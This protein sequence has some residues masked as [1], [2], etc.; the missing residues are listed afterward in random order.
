MIR[1]V[2]IWSL[3]VLLLTVLC[4]FTGNV[5]AFILLTATAVLIIVSACINLFRKSKIDIN[6]SFNSNGEKNEI[7]F[8]TLSITNNSFLPISCLYIKLLCKNSL[9]G[10]SSYIKEAVTLMPRKSK[11][12]PVSVQSSRCGNITFFTEN[13]KLYDFLLLFR[14]RI[15]INVTGNVLVYPVFLPVN[16]SLVNNMGTDD[17]FGDSFTSK[18]GFYSGDNFE[19]DEYKYGDSLKKI[20]WKLTS[21]FDRLMVT[22]QLKE[23]NNNIL[24]M[25]ETSLSKGHTFDV[26][27]RLT[28]SFVSISNSLTEANVRHSICWYNHVSEK[29][30]LYEINS[31]DSLIAVLPKILSVTFISDEKTVF[32]YYGE[33]YFDYEYSHTIYVSTKV[34][35]KVLENSFITN[36]I[37]TED[38]QNIEGENV[39]SFSSKSKNLGSIKI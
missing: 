24:L 15:K 33:N 5:G 20:H 35:D 18:L 34:Y 22:K 27:E 14:K 21:K 29:I 7:I 3:W 19:I 2:L 30:Y 12:I 9:T 17:T 1:S 11:E 13:I 25:L 32:D 37:C 28:E 23:T 31:T 36:F 26:L 4:L 6:L 16:I 38:N 39:I 8:G 10:E